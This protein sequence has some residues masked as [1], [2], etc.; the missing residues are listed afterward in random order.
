MLHDQ[1]NMFIDTH[2]CARTHTD[3]ANISEQFSTKWKDLLR[4]DFSQRFSFLRRITQ[5]P[6]IRNGQREMNSSFVN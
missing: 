4:A 2:A 5:R 1:C 6:F 3:I